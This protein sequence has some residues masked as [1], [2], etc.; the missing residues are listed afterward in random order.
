[1]IYVIVI[2]FIILIVTVGLNSGE[3]SLTDICKVCDK[4]TNLQELSDNDEMCQKCY[5]KFWDI[6]T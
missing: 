3:D 6:N 1:M 5:D 4:E 2:I